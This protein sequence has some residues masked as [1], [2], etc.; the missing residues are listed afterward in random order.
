[1]FRLLFCLAIV[2]H[3]VGCKDDSDG[4]VKRKVSIAETEE[5]KFVLL[6][7]GE[8]FIIKGAGGASQFDK[9]REAGG[10][11]VRLWDTT[12]LSVVLDS[13]HANDLSVI[14]GLPVHDNRFLDFYDNPVAVDAQ[15]EVFRAFVR[16]HKDHPALLMWCLGNELVFSSR[17]SYNKFYGAFNRLTDMIHQEDPDHPVTTSLLNF[18]KPHIVN[19]RLRCNL[20]VLSFNLYGSISSLRKELEDFEWFWDGPYILSEWGIDGAWGGREHT[21]WGAYI[22][23]TSNKKAEIYQQRYTENIP[24]EDPRFIGSCVFFWGSKQEGTHTWFSMFD[25]AGA[26]SQAV[27]VMQF[28]WTGKK[29]GKV[30]PEIEHML[31]NKK[32]SRDNIML[33]ANS[34]LSAELFL[35]DKVKDFKSISWEIF[36]EDWYR[37]NG[38]SNEERLKPLMREIHTSAVTRVNFKAP[39]REGP[40]RIFAT[41]YDQNGNF[42]TC[43]T[44]FYVIENE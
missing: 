1:M 35:L 5:G 41:I 31:V 11:T 33:S 44:P 4:Y 40:Y 13:A 34:N 28:L 23:D 6:K 32:G 16:K 17:P 27:D 22:E 25:E 18:H 24:S 26:R 38:K 30:F 8:P 39:Q 7:D 21:A 3:V 29:S 14:V 2:L 42:A 9:L 37:K 43:N 10:N 19:I 15:L 20:D 12:N 36:P